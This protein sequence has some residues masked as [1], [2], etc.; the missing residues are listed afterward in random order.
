MKDKWIWLF[1]GGRVALV[2]VAAAVG[3]LVDLE[4]LDQQAADAVR[5]VLELLFRLFGL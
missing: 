4:L 1:V 2:V 3:A 5:R